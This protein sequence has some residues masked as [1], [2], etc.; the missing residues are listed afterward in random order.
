[1]DDIYGSSIN[2]TYKLIF[3]LKR[4]ECY[5]DTQLNAY[6]WHYTALTAVTPATFSLR[7]PKIGWTQ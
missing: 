5:K 1:M 4:L 3:L 2:I 6:E 7:P